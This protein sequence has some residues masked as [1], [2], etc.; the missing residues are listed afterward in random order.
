MPRR[1]SRETALT[2]E[3]RRETQSRSLDWGMAELAG[4]QYGVV[5][6]QQLASIGMAESAIDRRI[7]A[8]R[9]HQLHRG[10]FA[11]GHRVVVRE[12]RLLAAVLYVGD[13]AVLS[14]RSA[15][16]LWGV[17]GTRGL[18]RIDVCAPRSARS[19]AAIRRHHVR[20]AASEL[21]VR[22]KI[23]V[24]TLART[25]FDIAAGMPMEAFEAAL[26]QAEYLHR[27]RLE[28]LER[29]LVIHPGRR[30]AATFKACLRRLERGPM[31]R[32]RSKLED[33]FAALL[34][35]T[36]LPRAELNV[37]LD[38]GKDMIEAD[39][40]WRERRVIVELDG[41]DAHATRVAFESD[42][43]RDRRLQAVGWRVI[44]VTW[45]QLDDPTALLA[46]LRRLRAGE[47]ASSVA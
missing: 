29:L 3:Y 25:L 31:G 45:R 27:F 2:V 43:E 21:A 13:G 42:R 44:R 37:L 20:Y 30:G 39:C 40:L 47:T 23:P 28:E 16:E 1:P 9:L 33:R 5:S 46:D 26:R 18:G 38:L 7:R 35:R 19:S 32:R 34:A 36:E 41:R 12:G 8:G 4:R 24:T 14:H 6:R 15:A 22:R 10:V 11:V 17:V